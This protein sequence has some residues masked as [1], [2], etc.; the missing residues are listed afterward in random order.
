MDAGEMAKLPRPPQKPQRGTAHTGSHFPVTGGNQVI[1]YTTGRCCFNDIAA[2]IGTATQAEHRIYIAGWLLQTDTWMLDEPPAPSKATY[3]LSDFL[4]STRAQVR[5]LTWRPP[6]VF[7]PIPNNQKWVDFINGLPNG[8]AIADSKLPVSATSGESRV[9]LGVHHQKIAVVVGYRGTIAF[10]GGMDLNNTRISNQGVEPLHDV[11]LRLTGP[12]AVQV[13]KTFQERWTDHPEARALEIS[14]FGANPNSPFRA[15]FPDPAPLADNRVPSCTLAPGTRSADRVVG[16]GRTY[17]DLRRFGGSVYGFATG[18]EYSAMNM[19]I[20]GIRQARQTIYLE[21]QYLS[22]AIVRAELVKKLAEKSF[23]YL[24]ILMTNSDSVPPGEFGYLRV[25]R[26]EFRRDLFAVDPKQER[27][28]MYALKNCPDPTRRWFAGSYVHSKTWIFDDEYAITG[29]ANCTDR[30]YTFDSEIVAG[31]S[32]SGFI[33][34]GPDAFAAAL[35]INLW[36]KHLGVPHSLVRDWRGGVKLWKKPP[37]SGMVYDDAQLE[38]DPAL[39][40]NFP[41]DPAQERDVQVGRIFFDTDG[42]H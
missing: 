9:S 38:V 14:R 26:N 16:I 6:L 28:G 8:A 29:S 30:S 23:Q 13:L 40:S 19:V 27:W 10:L 35:R 42:L 1:G 22:S 7:G 36:H 3:L 34:A 2:A 32:E 12:A 21:D 41:T 20:D 31:V 17:A 5:T 15:A 33:T 24:L 11:H 39:G 37:P 4:Q 18:G 25:F